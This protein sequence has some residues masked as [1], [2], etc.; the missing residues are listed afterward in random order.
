MLL[1]SSAA[2]CLSSLPGGVLRPS[3]AI[4]L[5]SVCPAPGDELVHPQIHADGSLTLPSELAFRLFYPLHKLGIGVVEGVRVFHD[6][7]GCEPL[8]FAEKRDSDAL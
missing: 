3:L 4:D 2:I 8:G 7:F 6:G 1:V 5:A